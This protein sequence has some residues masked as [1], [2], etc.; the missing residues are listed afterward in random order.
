MSANHH[1]NLEVVR[2][3]VWEVTS[4]LCCHVSLQSRA[5]HKDRPALQ[6]QPLGWSGARCA[7]CIQLVDEVDG[8]GSW[9]QVFVYTVMFG[10]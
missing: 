8:E 2:C 3:D 5:R 9:W 7:A 10:L 6:V 1:Y 4:A